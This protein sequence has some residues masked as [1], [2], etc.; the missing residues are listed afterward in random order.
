MLMIG[1]IGAFEMR[2]AAHEQRMQLLRALV[3]STRT[4]IGYYEQLAKDGKLTRE[5][6]QAQAREALRNVRF[7]QREYFFIYS[8]DGVNVLHPTQPHREGKPFIAEKDKL[9]KLFVA[10]IVRAGQTGGGFVD[11]HFPRPNETE[12]VRKV[13]YVAPVPD[14]QW[15]VGTGLYVDDVEADFREDLAIN[16]GIVIVLA[17]V[18]LALVIAI[19]RSVMRQVGGEPAVAV[20]AM[21]KVVE[22]DLRAG[23]GNAP[24]GSM[25]AELD[26]L[27]S[28][29]RNTVSE[30]SAGA[31]KVGAATADI[32]ATSRQV[33]GSAQQ[34]TDSTQTMAAAME[35]LTVSITHIS[36]NAGETERQ[37]IES[38]E[39]AVAGERQVHE[40][41]EEMRSL[42][43][44][45]VQASE[46]IASLS[47][48]ANE[49]GGIATAINDIAAQTNL[50]A[51]NAAIEA[52][53]AGEQGR[54]FA[55]VAD[56][57]R[58]LAERTT[59]ATLQIGQTVSAI[60]GE[61]E[62]AVSAMDAASERARNSVNS[63]EQSADMLRRIAE[64][65]TRA[66]ELVAE[67][68][69]STR[70]Q[71]IASNSLAGQIEQ[72]AQMVEATSQGMHATATATEE[73]TRVAG[74]LTSVVSRFRC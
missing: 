26:T 51:L 31:Q 17:G 68:A 62:A 4:Q 66:R 47:A 32:S 3:E 22:G 12:A 74:D 46:R 54:G 50:L 49:V 2:S 52:A 9:G 21:K 8:S 13:A 25:L 5:Q 61:S 70:E 60:R 28:R 34:Q 72:V 42:A 71:G 43:D 35:E 56:E 73:L 1:V 30:I 20:Q 65:A 38:S 11:Y 64:G 18:V 27:I 40:A 33:A 37:S 36:E 23:I 15:V 55:V 53:R 19:G 63:A 10:D 57:V 45:V 14:W 58:K 7:Q 67:V 29:L 44:A 48:R 6:A 69:N 59:Q 16:L 24:A 39:M 41:A